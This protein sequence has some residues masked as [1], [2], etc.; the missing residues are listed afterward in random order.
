MAKITKPMS[1][2]DKARLVTI[3]AR[4]L[5]PPGFTKSDKDALLAPL[6][7]QKK[8]NLSSTVLSV[9]DKDTII[10]AASNNSLFDIMV[11]VNGINPNDPAG[12]ESWPVLKFYKLNIAGNYV[13]VDVETVIPIRVGGGG[14]AGGGI[15]SAGP[16]P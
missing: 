2:V 4:P 10:E 7:F 3:K 9:I 6:L 12:E 5:A 11:V 16:P 15:A 13:E 8:L 14:G 1:A